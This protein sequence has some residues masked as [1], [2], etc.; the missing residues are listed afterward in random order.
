MCAVSRAFQIFIQKW[1][2]ISNIKVI[3]IF[4]TAAIFMS[5]VTVFH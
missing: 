1:I 4:V 3:N 2:W 5:V